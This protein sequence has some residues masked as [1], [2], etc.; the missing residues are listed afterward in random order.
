MLIKKRRLK[1]I[2]NVKNDIIH[3]GIEIDKLCDEYERIISSLHEEA[4]N[5]DIKIVDLQKEL[6]ESEDH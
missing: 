2:I 4:F 1:Q 5:R 3:I 6:K